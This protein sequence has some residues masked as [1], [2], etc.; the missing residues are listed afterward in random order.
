MSATD[1]QRGDYSD[2]IRRPTQEESDRTASRVVLAFIAVM[3]LVGAAVH[4]AYDDD[5]FNSTPTYVPSTADLYG[6]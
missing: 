4:G 2:G 5:K 1:P 3:I 6:P